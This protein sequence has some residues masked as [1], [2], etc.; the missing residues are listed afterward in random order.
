MVAALVAHGVTK[1]MLNLALL[2]AG[3][4]PAGCCGPPQANL[5]QT[6]PEVVATLL[7]AGAEVNWAEGGVTALHAAAG[8]G[9][10]AVVELL[11]KSGAD[12]EAIDSDLS[13]P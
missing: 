6:C 13:L 1:Q 2:A 12:A 3:E 4:G 7:E 9:N 8:S 11:L 10:A 5:R